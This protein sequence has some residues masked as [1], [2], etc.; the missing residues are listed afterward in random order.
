MTH[1]ERAFF[2]HLHQLQADLRRME[3]DSIEPVDRALGPER[4]V[5][6]CNLYCHRSCPPDR[7]SEDRGW[8]GA[9]SA[10]RL[11]INLCFDR[12]TAQ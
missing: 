7:D 4:E 1:L 11:T 5:A 10:G 6:T 2:K 9:V 12:A 8:C 3:F